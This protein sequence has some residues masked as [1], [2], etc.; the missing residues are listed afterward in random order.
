MAEDVIIERLAPICVIQ[1]NQDPEKTAEL[2]ELRETRSY[3]EDQGWATMS[4]EEA[5]DRKVADE[6]VR[7]LMLIGE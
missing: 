5:P 1:F 6:C 2:E 4:G 7:L 3:V